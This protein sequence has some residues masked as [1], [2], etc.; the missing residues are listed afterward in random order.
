M[1]KSKVFVL[2]FIGVFFT[3]LFSG[4]A[5]FADELSD[6][7]KKIE[8]TSKKL[9][10][11]NTL[12]SDLAKKIEDLTKNLSATQEDINDLNAKISE[13]EAKLAEINKTLEQKRLEL[14]AKIKARNTIVSD[15]YE[16]NSL[17][18]LEFF[19]MSFDNTSGTLS[20]SFTRLSQSYAAKRVMAETTLDAIGSLNTDIT[21][22]EKE[23]KEASDLKTGLD[24]EK[25]K[26]VA[27]KNSLTVQQ[28]QV[29]EKINSLDDQIKKVTSDLS[30]LTSKQQELLRAKFGETSSSDTI[31]DSEQA[32]TPLPNAPFKPAF[33]FLTFGFPHRVG[34][35]QYGM[36]GR[37][38]AGQDYKKILEAYFANV[39]VSGSCDKGKTIPVTGY[40]N[41]KLEDTYMLGIAEMP[42]YWGGSGGME[43]LKA[44]AVLARTYALNYTGYYWDSASRSLKKRGR[45]VSICTTQAC[46]V[47]NG[48][49]KS[50][51]WKQAVQATCGQTL[52]YNGAPIT[53]WY[54]STAG[55]YTRTS[56]QV[57]GSDR[58]WSK[59]IKDTAC[60]G[61]LFDCAY[62][63]PKYGKSPWFYKAWGKNPSTGNAWMSDS[64]AQDIF[65]AYL[66][67]EKNT[68]Y[69]KYLSPVDKG[70]WSRD[71][72]IS[73]LN[74]VG[75]SPVGSISDITMRD[76]GTGFTTSVVLK[77]A[78]Y[79]SKSFEGYKFK[80]IFNLRA[81]GS[82]VLWTS[83]FNVVIN[84]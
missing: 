67:S 42:E 79:S 12:K 48:R 55:G 49:A 39:S 4:R 74:K 29:Q 52:N 64:E 50:S 41:L 33:A 23:R 82:L 44:Q 80:S 77:S 61:D 75:V 31:G 83:F 36:Y 19:L 24:V 9:S 73:E 65:N 56:G 58:P 20:D 43:A 40:G 3:L 60:S 34:A 2:F 15:Y 21:E 35:N 10:D 28:V 59:A 27:L 66:L 72:V 5:G 57:W 7:N 22:Y 84:N 17:T 68:S 37:S 18:A 45:P 16:E 26:L 30:N 6:T 76:D 70:G 46:Q 54:A 13:M 47:Y 8:S 69:N 38:K 71:K 1:P 62:D 11:L 78:N 14:A 63:G 32:S 53:A 81:P 51:Y 25:G